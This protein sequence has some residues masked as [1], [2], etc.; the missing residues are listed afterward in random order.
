MTINFAETTVNLEL[1]GKTHTL[2]FDANS[3]AAYEN[4]TGKFYLETVAQLYDAMRPAIEAR[5]AATEA[6][7][8]AKEPAVAVSAFDIIHKVPMR[9]LLALVWA[10]MHEYD[11]KDDPVWPLTLNQVGRLI[12]LQDVPRVFTAFLHGQVKNSPSAEELGE[13]RAP[14]EQAAVKPNGS[15]AAPRTEAASGGGA[16]TALPEDAFT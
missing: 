16:S 7:S 10:G 4:A 12:Q 6:D 13:S 3:M 1:G 5:A 9:D 15:V 8:V 11:A 2:R 14:S